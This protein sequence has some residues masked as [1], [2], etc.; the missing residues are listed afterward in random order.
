MHLLANTQ[1]IQKL[2]QTYNIELGRQSS[3]IMAEGSRE[4]KACTSSLCTSHMRTEG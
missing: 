3:C 2:P 4:G 1:L